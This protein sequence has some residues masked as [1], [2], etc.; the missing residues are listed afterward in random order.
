MNQ[1]RPRYDDEAVNL[2]VAIDD[3]IA[4][5]A[6]PHDQRVRRARMIRAAIEGQVEYDAPHPRTDVLALLAQA[7]IQQLSTLHLDTAWFA[8]QLDRLERHV[9]ARAGSP[10]P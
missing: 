4:Q 1:E 2:L 7:L 10:S 9:L 8:E 5:L 3:Q 6:P